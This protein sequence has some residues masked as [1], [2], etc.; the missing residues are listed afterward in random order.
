MASQGINTSAGCTSPLLE[1]GSLHQNYV[2]GLNVLAASDPSKNLITKQPWL[3]EPSGSEPFDAQNNIALPAI[4][5]SATVLSYT[6]PIGFDG[7]VK[8]LSN[9]LTVC[10]FTEGDGSI[11]WRL[12]ING[13]AVRNFSNI[14]VEKGTIQ[15]PRP[16]SPLRLFSGDQISWIVYN[17]SSALVGGT[18]CSLSGYIYPSTGMS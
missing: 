11:I 5:A 17:I 12:F 1:L 10:G 4:G 7:V 3:D 8:A 16:I 15:I 14:L 2:K 13:R 18:V 9:N 6:V